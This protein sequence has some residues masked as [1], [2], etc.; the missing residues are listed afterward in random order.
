MIQ[1]I[2]PHIYDNTYDRQEIQPDDC[3]LKFENRSV[4]LKE[5]GDL[6]QAKDYESYP[7][8]SC[9][10]LFKIDQT[11]VYISLGE[12]SP[13]SLSPVTLRDAIR[14][15]DNTEG[16]LLY[17]AYQLNQWYNDNRYCGR[18]G[19][20]LKRG[21]TE[22]S[23]VCHKCGNTIYPRIS[24]AVIIA[25]RNQDSLLMSVYAN[26]EYKHKALLAGF[27]EIGETP[28]DTVRREVFEEVG[29]KVKNIQYFSSQPWGIESDLLLGYVCDVDGDTTVTL[30]EN[31]LAQAMWVKR[32]DIE[33]DDR[34]S[35]LTSTMM[36]AFRNHK[37]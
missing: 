3:L 12:L 8:E 30:D 20:H 28:E 36:Q 23:L 29:L 9:Y 26:R 10:Y 16:F 15:S 24:P 21:E 25:L 37:I 7:K 2:E 34:Q 32:E 5:N 11:R 1:N 4:Y 17:T 6:P 27:I 33:P 19:S 13:V 35:S 22:R 14:Q 31:E 18:C